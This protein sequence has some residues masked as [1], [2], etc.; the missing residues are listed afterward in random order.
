MIQASG[1]NMFKST[2]T[3]AI[4]AALSVGTLAH[5]QDAPT[6]KTTQQDSQSQ[7]AAQE[8]PDEQ[9]A[10]KLATITVTGS[11]IPQTQIETAQPIIT[12]TAAQLQAR[13]FTTIA[14]AL[15]QSSFS[16]G[17]VQGAQDTNSFSPGAKTLSFFGLPVGFT[18]Y[19]V[20][21]RPMG[22]FPGLYNG[23]DTFNNISGIPVAMVDHIDILP[24]GQSSLYGS[25]AIAGVIN[26]VLK[27]HVD[28]PT[29]DVRYGWHTGGGGATRRISFADDFTVGKF[30]S[31]VGVQF[32]NTQPIWAKDRDLTSQF[33]RDGTSP[34][35]ASRDYLV[36]SAG[37]AESGYLFLDP[38]NCANVTGGFNG[39]EKKQFRK[40][41]GNYCGS[42]YSPGEATLQN[43][44]KTANLYTHNTFDVNANIQLYGDLLYNYEEQKYTNGSSTSFWSSQLYA[45][46]PAGYFF[47]D[48][49]GNLPLIQHAFTPEE[50]GGYSNIMNKQT[51]NS[52]MLTLGGRGTFGESNWD[53][54]LGFT[55]SDDQLINRDFQRF[56]APLEAYYE[57]HVMGPKLGTYYGYPVFHP[58]YAAVYN[59]VSP[60]DYRG[61]TGYTTNHSKTWDN[62]LRG[63]LTNAS[64]FSLPGGDAGV[65]VVL[66]GGNQGWDSSPDPR[67]LSTITD[68]YGNISPEVWGTSA[69]PGGGHRSRYAATTEFRFP[70]F[71]Q[72]TLDASGRYDSYNVVGQ[73]VSHKTYNL[74]LEYRP[75]D[76]LLLRGRYGTAFK[77][78]T[79]SDEFQGPSGYF[80]S[81]RDDL[82]CGRL[83]FDPTND[84]CPVPYNS[85][86]F[87]G[88]T[89]GNPALQPITA[90]VWSYG[91]AWAP[92]ERMSIT[93]DYLHYDISNEVT[94][95]NASQLSNT[96]YLCDIGTIDAGTQTCKSA[97]DLITRGP[98]KT[99]GGVPLLGIISNISTPKLNQAK[100]KVNAITASFNYR[101]VLGAFG[102]LAY[103]LS[104]ADTLK[105]T[106]QDFIIDE[107][108]DYLRHPGY[109]YD[110]KTKANASLTWSKNVWS[111]TAYVNRYG[112]SPNYAAQQSDTYDPTQAKGTAK[113]GAWITWNA[114]VSYRPVDSL[115]LSLLIN[116]VFDKMPPK[117]RTY[118]GTSGVPYNTLNYNVYGRA[119]YLEANYKL[120]KFN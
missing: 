108:V 67:L 19:L 84:A 113:L 62:M 61:F 14:E 15:Q 48:R 55:H 56:T 119:I 90:K 6:T 36:L 10:K 82:N 86:Q 28:A 77:V 116:N 79:L 4:L 5:A 97:F 110:F 39:T 85:A 117:D 13:G 120:G 103:N 111:A 50:V 49:T 8:A 69:T 21:G 68:V 102:S 18:K 76:T 106:V 37:G 114:S 94:Q 96:Q 43:H 115:A 91:I 40:G 41:S 29:L 71:K 98:G 44:D 22:N 35:T 30:T 112:R 80:N 17:S 33:F 101:Q 9:K 3:I 104:Y 23:S 72:V 57:S 81:V 26:I 118:P 53:Y 70:V 59:P 52:Y 47:D 51:E 78:P 38:N 63:Q 20:D 27:K 100:E 24:G 25:D 83:G 31:L 93:A 75:F 46:A 60:A 88:L 58:D 11:L 65:A 109:S 2:L 54:D 32:E 34:Q 12:I 92:L 95:V 74:G 87:K 16:N 1:G 45:A 105:H 7:T 66:E 73:T 99:Q 42:I 64:L 107:P 89:Q